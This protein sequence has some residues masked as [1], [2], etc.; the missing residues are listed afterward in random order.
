M[1]GDATQL[2][3][4]R[5]AIVRLLVR[6][7]HWAYRAVVFLEKTFYANTLIKGPNIYPSWWPS[8]TKDDNAYH[9]SCAGT[10]EEKSDAFISICK[11]KT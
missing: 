1:S 7:P 4:C 11:D 5:I 9:A 3:E 8:L 10:C 2:L 6:R